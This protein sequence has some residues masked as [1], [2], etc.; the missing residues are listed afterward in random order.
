MQ[1]YA[2]GLAHLRVFEKEELVVCH[3]D[4]WQWRLFTIAFHPRSICLTDRHSLT[5]HKAKLSSNLTVR[6]VFYTFRSCF[7]LTYL[8]VLL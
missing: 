6:T 2:V 8:S 1:L 3:V 7:H 5:P 4:S